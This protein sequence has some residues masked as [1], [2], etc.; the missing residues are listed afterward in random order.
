M[1]IDEHL[2]VEE[3]GYLK[4]S[5][6][7]EKRSQRNGNKAVELLIQQPLVVVKFTSN[8]SSETTG[9][10]QFSFL[11][12]QRGCEMDRTVLHLGCLLKCPRG[13]KRTGASASRHVNAPAALNGNKNM[14][15]TK[16]KT[17]HMADG[18]FIS[19]SYVLWSGLCSLKNKTQIVKGNEGS[20]RK[21]MDQSPAYYGA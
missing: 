14:F 7:L 16:T 11:A 10:V 18:S 9:S 12:S 8:P 1:D 4:R 3:A 15:L 13:T 6:N 21:G 20:R 17:G 2:Q 19:S 5:L